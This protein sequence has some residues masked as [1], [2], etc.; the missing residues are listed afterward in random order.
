MVSFSACV[1]QL[2]TLYMHC[3]DGVAWLRD[4]LRLF[5]SVWGKS[6]NFSHTRKHNIIF[7]FV[8]YLNIIIG[9]ML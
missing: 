9:I 7:V 2:I 8:D 5:R 6:C 3:H 4:L 1:V